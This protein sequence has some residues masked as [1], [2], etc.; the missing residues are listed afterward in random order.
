MTEHKSLVEALV[1]FQ[2]EMPVVGKDQT[3]TVPMKSGGKYS[4]RYADL[5]DI[6][7]AATP[8]LTA[9]GLAFTAHPQVTESGQLLLTG[10]LHHTSGQTLDGS[11]PL[12]GHTPQ[13]V[14]SAITYARRYLLGCLTGIV[15]DEDDDGATAQNAARARQSRPP[16]K[17]D[18]RTDL[19]NRIAHGLD[20]MGIRDALAKLLWLSE[21]VGRDV[22]TPWELTDDEMRHVLTDLEGVPA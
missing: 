21:Q 5:A 22:G 10:M 9:H 19:V 12:S 3:A 18:P 4:Y 13:E 15:T 17:V 1:A 8:H 2:A 6:I 11:L 16:A 7:R 20:Q 14:G